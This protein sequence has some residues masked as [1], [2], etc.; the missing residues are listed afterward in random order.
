MS[1]IQFS[2]ERVKLKTSIWQANCWPA[3]ITFAD[4]S[5]VHDAGVLI[6]IYQVEVQMTSK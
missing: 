3:E 4:G 1:G 5:F 2:T 6:I